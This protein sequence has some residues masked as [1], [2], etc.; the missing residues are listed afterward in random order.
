MSDER[1]YDIVLYGATGFT[2]ALVAEY[3]AAHAPEGLRWAIAGRSEAKLA[4]VAQRLGLDLP[5][6]RADAGDRASLDA[7]ARSTRVV[8]TT[9]GPYALY[10]EP[11]VAACVEAGAHYCDLTGET[12][13]VSDMLPK[14]HEAARDK[15]ARIVNFC[16]YDSVPSDICTLALVQHLR[17]AHGQGTGEVKAFHAAK[18]GLS[19]GTAASMLTMIEQGRSRDLTKRLLLNPEDARDDGRRRRNKDITGPIYDADVGAWVA[20][21]FMGPVNTR[22]VRRSEALLASIGQPYGSEF[23]YKEAMYLG[24]KAGRLSATGVAAGLGAFFGLLSWGPTRTLV[25]RRLPSPGEGPSK[26]EREAGWT[27]CIAFA[28]GDAGARARCELFAHG[29]PGYKFTS[30]IL[31]ECALALALDA[32]K[33][34]GGPE[35]G[36]LLTPASGI[37]PVL[38]DRLRAAGV[39]IEVTDL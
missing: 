15:A 29:D 6:L 7:M 22:A 13:W 31:S 35:W 10:G 12:P 19:G 5:Q 8:I 32:D 14:Y 20:P 17:E 34:V 33:L 39:K 9:V 24:A 36:G 28:T 3:L 11:L 16:G 4:A 26:D 38:I 18:G 37:G 21:F 23:S 30:L 1:S 25:S 2:G 27:K